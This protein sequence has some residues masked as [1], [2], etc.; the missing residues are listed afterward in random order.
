LK[1]VTLGIEKFG[2][3]LGL[4]EKRADDI[5]GGSLVKDLEGQGFFTRLYRQPTEH[6]KYGE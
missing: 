4:R 2:A 3:K 5:T 1:N 6:G